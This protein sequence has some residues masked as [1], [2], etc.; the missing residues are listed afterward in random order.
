M[1]LTCLQT[2]LRSKETCFSYYRMETEA[3]WASGLVD[4]RLSA[5]IRSAT[6]CHLCS[7]ST[8]LPSFQAGCPMP[9]RLL[10][11]AIG[12]MCVFVHN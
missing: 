12:A 3:Q 8:L 1:L 11:A 4:K 10:S 7:T 6:I 9:V 5:A 2:A